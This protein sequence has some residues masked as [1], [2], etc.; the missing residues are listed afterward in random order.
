MRAALAG[1]GEPQA[2]QQRDHLAR[3]Q[4]G[5]LAPHGVAAGAALRDENRLDTDKL[6]LQP[7]FPVL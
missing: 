1:L 6:G 3:L 4:N 7:R 2:L 5:R